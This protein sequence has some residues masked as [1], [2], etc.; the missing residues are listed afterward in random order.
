MYSVGRSLS[1]SED[2]YEGLMLQ[3]GLWIGYSFTDELDIR[4]GGV[5][6]R[7]S[8]TNRTGS[9]LRDADGTI[10]GAD[11]ADA[12]TGKEK[13]TFTLRYNFE[14]LRFGYYLEFIH[15]DQDRETLPDQTYTVIRSKATMGVSF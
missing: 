15:K 3:G 13:G 14:A 7:W 10:T 8:E 6:D 11:Y 5:I 2:N 1:L 12:S 4:I 9:L